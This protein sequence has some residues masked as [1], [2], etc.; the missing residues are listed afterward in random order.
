MIKKLQTYNRQI[1]AAVSV[2]LL[3]VFLAPTAVTQCSRGGAG[4]SDTA[5]ARTAD[6][7]TLTLGD[8]QDMRAQL[9]VLEVMGGPVVGRLGASKSPEH[10]WLLV[11]E[12]RDSG[13]VGGAGDGRTMLD[14]TAARSGAKPDDLLMQ[15]ASSARQQPQVVLDTLA[16]L[17]G[18]ERL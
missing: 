8:L 9:A 13:L 14:E 11:K 16:N 2:L 3:I 12:A 17:R 5:W 18:V 6:G 10:W 1:L 15:L 4:S 7:T